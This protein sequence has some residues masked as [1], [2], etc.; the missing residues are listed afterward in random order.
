MLATCAATPVARSSTGQDVGAPA[1]PRG[2]ICLRS[3]GAIA[4]RGRRLALTIDA[5]VVGARAQLAQHGPRNRHRALGRQRHQRLHVERRRRLRRQL[6]PADLPVDRQHVANLLP[7][8]CACTVPGSRGPPAR[9]GR[10]PRGIADRDS[11]DRPSARARLHR[12]RARPARAS[13]RRSAAPR[14]DRRRRCRVRRPAR[15]HRFDLRHERVAC[16][17]AAPDR[18]RRQQRAF[19]RDR[20]VRRDSRP[21][22]RRSPDA[23]CPSSRTPTRGS[24]SRGTSARTSDSKSPSMPGSEAPL[25]VHG[26]LVGRAR[27]TTSSCRRPYRRSR[28]RARPGGPLRS[29]R[30]ETRCSRVF[31][32]SLRGQSSRL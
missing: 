1:A 27:P 6:G 9:R 7:R 19:E 28:R 31:G 3:A 22:R 29:R 11:A 32:C 15:S 24:M 2:R 16:G 13:S 17:K 5:S 21:C 8:R 26:K 23:R 14:A 25:E 30:R 10:R 4:A 12:S 20:V 18:R